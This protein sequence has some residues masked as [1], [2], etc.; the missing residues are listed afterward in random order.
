MLAA[1]KIKDRRNSTNAFKAI[2]D[3]CAQ[4]KSLLQKDDAILVYC[5]YSVMVKLA[6]AGDDLG[7]LFCKFITE[8]CLIVLGST[9]PITFF[10]K[11]LQRMGI[12]EARKA[13]LPIMKAYF[14]V[15][16]KSLGSELQLVM[17]LFLK[18][19]QYSIGPVDLAEVL[20]TTTS[21]IEKLRHDPYLGAKCLK[22][23]KTS[24][25]LLPSLMTNDDE[26]SLTLEYDR[27][28]AKSDLW[29]PGEEYLE[30]DLEFDIIPVIAM[31]EELHGRYLS[32]EWH[33]K[34]VHDLATQRYIK[35]HPRVLKASNDLKQHKIRWDRTVSPNPAG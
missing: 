31:V 27:V 4:Y 35:G 14:D 9:H 17:T 25:Q 11:N 29:L 26:D 30:D 3:C 2:D 22:Y 8:L 33:Y 10:W 1:S 16:Y 6:N 19:Y 32:A 34:Y 7:I 28:F 24:A 15:V 18:D 12:L 5:T 13:M 20:A 23:W 21:S